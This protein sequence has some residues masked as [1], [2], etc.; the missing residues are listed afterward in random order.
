MIACLWREIFKK[1]HPNGIFERSWKRNKLQKPFALC[2]LMFTWCNHWTEQ[3]PLNKWKT[4]LCEFYHDFR[5]KSLLV[6]SHQPNR[7]VNM[8]RPFLDENMKKKI[9]YDLH[10][11]ACTSCRV[12]L[13]LNHVESYSVMVAVRHGQ[14]YV[15]ASV[16]LLRIH[17]KRQICEFHIS[18]HIKRPNT[19]TFFS[20]HVPS[21]QGNPSFFFFLSR[22]AA[23]SLFSFSLLLFFFSSFVSVDI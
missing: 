10:N 1:F 9:I 3:V 17:C 8:E 22:F 15:Y 14:Q 11:C 20:H 21:F 5:S 6:G 12:E 19:F 16:R 7:K 23:A 18:E 2:D 13:T 4:H